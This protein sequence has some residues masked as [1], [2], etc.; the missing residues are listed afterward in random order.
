MKNIIKSITIVFVFALFLSVGIKVRSNAAVDVKSVYS[1][2][3]LTRVKTIT[4][5]KG[6]KAT[7]STTVKVSPNKAAN[8]AVTYTSSNKK[9]AK[10]SKKGVITAK[11][12][13]K[14]KITVKS[15]KNKKKKATINVKV[16]AGMVTK[17][18]FNSQSKTTITLDPD[19]SIVVKPTIKT[20][21]KKCNKALVWSTSNAQVATVTAKGKITV[22]TPGIAKITAKSTDGTNKSDYLFVKVTSTVISA[23]TA[24]VVAEF[25]LD[26]SKV[27]TDFD[28]IVK[29]AGIKDENNTKV[30]LIINDRENEETKTVAEAREYLRT[31]IEENKKLPT[32][33]KITIPNKQ[34]VEYGPVVASIPSIREVIIDD[35]HFTKITATTITVDGVKM[36]YKIDGKNLILGGDQ[37]T[38]Q[39]ISKL[40][41]DNIIKAEKQ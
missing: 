39:S 22:G 32:S 10:V 38:N 31:L 19:K 1:V 23:G 24:D 35:V 13:G 29:A 21:G 37:T 8:R 30:T 11:K 14:A 9:V 15:K 17:V 41:K 12:V 5:A 33:V 28:V 7:L 6:K 26:A 3:S 27:M 36:S 16:V 34:L 4:L 25:S 18:S 20:K 40:V 2:N